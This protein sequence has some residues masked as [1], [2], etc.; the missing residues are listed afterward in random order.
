MVDIA[1]HHTGNRID[2]A[3]PVNFVAKKLHPDGSAGPIG[4]I[5][6]QRI[7]PQAK[8]ITGEIQV[9]SLVTNLRQFA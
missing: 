2:L 5:N 7:A 1:L 4:R 8:L 6:L 3:D 9:I